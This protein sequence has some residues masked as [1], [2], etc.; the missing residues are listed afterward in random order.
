MIAEAFPRNTASRLPWPEPDAK[1]KEMW[2][3]RNPA[4]KSFSSNYMASQARVLFLAATPSEK[5]FEEFERLC[6]ERRLAPTTAETYWSTW[7]GVQKAM[8]I[9]PS[10]A[11]VRTTRI[12]KARA[13][14]YPVQFPTPISPSEMDR[15]VETFKAELPTFT[16]FAMFSYL[17]G[18]R[19]SDV[20][21]LAVNDV[22]VQDDLLMVTIRRGKTMEVTQPYTLWL[23]MSSYPAEVI[24]QA[25]DA[26]I[27]QQR[28]FIMTSTNSDAERQQ[29]LNT[30]RDMITSINDQLEL[31]SFRRG[32]LHR[33]AQ[34]GIP[35]EEVRLFS[36]HADVA[37]LMR[38]LNW[39]QHAQQQK[40]TMIE[41]LKVSTTSLT[42]TRC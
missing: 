37:M 9:P 3:Q 26:A 39:G 6:F 30:I 33:L 10:E 13:A 35:L 29:V 36:R 25:R 16:A 32:G 27:Q 12:M 19:I 23:K 14:A 8:S 1:L 28:V 42:T 18:Q 24:V 17:Q 21:Q 11:D 5:R 22:V 2:L 4:F 41:A 34:S 20:I 38:Y 31:R 40:E 15:L 7:L